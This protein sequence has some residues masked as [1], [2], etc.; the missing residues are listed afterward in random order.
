MQTS[1]ADAQANSGNSA[2]DLTSMQTDAKSIQAVIDAAT[3]NGV[4]LLDAATTLKFALGISADDTISMSTVDLSDSSAGG[5]LQ[6]ATNGTTTA[7]D[8]LALGS[9]DVNST[10]IGTTLTNIGAAISKV[11]SYAT[12]IG[13][14][15]NA[16]TAVGSYA[17]Q[18][19]SNY[20]GLATSLT[21]ADTTK[22]SAQE[23][24]LQTQIELATQAM[25]IANS[26]GQY[27]VKLLGG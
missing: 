13:T 26:M 22:L 7:S 19:A 15:Q 23:S 5:F 20:S 21:A 17:T 10:N 9:T 14:T 2:T 11:D 3:S 16:I 6:N 4:N 18:M 24:A 1:A 27:T 8:L 12:T 25:S